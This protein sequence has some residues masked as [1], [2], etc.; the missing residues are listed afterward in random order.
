MKKLTTL[1][2]VLFVLSCANYQTQTNSSSFYAHLNKSEDYIIKKEG[3]EVL[4]IYRYL[5]DTTKTPA[6]ATFAIFFSGFVSGSNH[7]NSNDTIVCSFMSVDEFKNET[8]YRAVTLKWML[9][10]AEKNR[11]YWLDFLKDDRSVVYYIEKL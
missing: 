5:V 1:L 9:D 8:I 11:V 6:T 4:V 2:I 10:E 7:A 3:D